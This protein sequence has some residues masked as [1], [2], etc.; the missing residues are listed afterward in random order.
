VNW[1]TP[2]P[3]EKLPWSQR[4]I[5]IALGGGLLSLLIVAALLDP[6]PRGLGT[7]QRLGLPP[8]TFQQW[9]GYRCPSCGMTTA[10]SNL[11]RGRVGAALRANVGGVVLALASLVLAPW[12]LVAGCY[13][14]WWWRPLDDRLALG[15]VVALLLITLLEWGLRLWLG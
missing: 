6:D 1:P 15:F 8:C 10:W 13:G 12:T 9:T 11:A 7:H 14:R 3:S 4:S 5:L 2:C